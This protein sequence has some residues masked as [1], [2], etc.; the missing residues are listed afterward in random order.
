LSDLSRR[1]RK[2]LMVG[3]ADGDPTV[4]DRVVGVG[5]DQVLGVVVPVG[6][7]AVDP[8]FE[9]GDGGDAGVG[10]GFAV[11]RR[12]PALDEVEP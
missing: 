8:G 11:E 5:P 2:P 3:S 12:E 6:D 9:F 7:P 10:R 1:R 4:D